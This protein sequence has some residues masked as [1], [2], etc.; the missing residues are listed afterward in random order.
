MHQKISFGL[1]ITVSIVFGLTYLIIGCLEIILAIL[2]LNIPLIPHDFMG[3]FVN[4]TTAAI[5]FFGV[6]ELLNQDIRGIAF[7]FFGT[8]FGL[9]FSGLYLLI[10]LSSIATKTIIYNERLTTTILL[11]ETRIE[12]LLLPILAIVLLWFRNHILRK[13][14]Y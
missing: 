12:I 6:K 10:M 11:E 5:Y 13:F 7:P 8:I 3:G 2:G 1:S 9:G 14:S 4:I